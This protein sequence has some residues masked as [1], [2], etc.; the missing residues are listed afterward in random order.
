MHTHSQMSSKDYIVQQIMLNQVICLR[1][2]A[3]D[4]FLDGLCSLRFVELIVNFPKEFEPLFLAEMASST[5]PS[6]ANI[7]DMLQLSDDQ[8]MAVFNMLKDYVKSLTP[9]G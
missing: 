2:A 7:A 9:E 8:D 3:I 5:T 1:K 4:Q 6:N